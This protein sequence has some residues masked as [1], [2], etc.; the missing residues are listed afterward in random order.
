MTGSQAIGI[1]PIGMGMI[2]FVALVFFRRRAILLDKHGVTTA[3]VVLEVKKLE[4]K[5][6]RPMPPTSTSLT[7]A[8]RILTVR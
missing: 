4:G 5:L 3:A 6:A 7:F 2:A 8:V 1:L